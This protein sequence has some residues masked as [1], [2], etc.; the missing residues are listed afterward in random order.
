MG[1]DHC[2]GEEEHVAAEVRI[3][4]SCSLERRRDNKLEST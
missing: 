4:N 1:I 3:V 2:I